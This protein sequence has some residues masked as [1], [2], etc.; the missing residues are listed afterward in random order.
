MLDQLICIALSNQFVHFVGLVV[1]ETF[2]LL[3]NDADA[4]TYLVQ[5]D[6]VS[7]LLQLYQLR[8]DVNTASLSEEE[9]TSITALRLVQ[10]PRHCA[11][12]GETWPY[13]LASSY[14]R[15]MRAVFIVLK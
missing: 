13:L 14:S 9:K 12:Q 3:A 4:H 11:A 1:A 7:A 5:P 6:I 8:T 15:P 2:L 10:M